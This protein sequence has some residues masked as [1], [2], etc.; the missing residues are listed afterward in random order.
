M[1]LPPSSIIELCFQT[2]NNIFEGD[3]LVTYEPGQTKNTNSPTKAQLV[4]ADLVD[5]HGKMT[6][7]INV[8]NN[9]IARFLNLVTPGS[10]LLI[11]DLAIWNKGIYDRGDAKCFIF[12]QEKS[13]VEN[14]EQ[15]FKDRNLAPDTTI[16][17]LFA[18]NNP[19]SIGSIGEIVIA[20]Q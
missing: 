4:H 2:H 16:K 19:Y 20:Y 9:L 17:S 11:K 8:N 12:I 1:I 14:I 5:R 6:I 3:V 15:I 13:T 10:S 18:S 7:T